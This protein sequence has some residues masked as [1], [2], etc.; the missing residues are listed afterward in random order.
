MLRSRGY[1]VVSAHEVGMR[2]KSDDEQLCYAIENKRTFLTFNARH[3]VPLTEELHKERRE[4]F[5][6]II[7]KQVS[8]SEIIRL[9]VKMLNMCKVSDLKNSLLW[10]Q[11]FK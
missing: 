11:S 1:D 3:F 2:G 4:H 10:L 9:V 8:L 6:V 5:G 7:S